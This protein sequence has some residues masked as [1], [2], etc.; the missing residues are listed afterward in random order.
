MVRDTVTQ[1]T[2][3]VDTAER[4]ALRIELADGEDANVFAGLLKK[5]IEDLIEGDDS[6]IRS[7]AKIRGKLGLHSTDPEALVTLVFGEDGIVIRNGFDEDLDGRITGT[8]KLQTETLVGRA[9]PYAAMLRRR[10][11]VGI[12]WSRPLFT[13]QTYSFLKVPK[14]MRP[15]EDA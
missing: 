4:S 1:T 6:K 11:S 14:W 13:L 10:L 7:A 8:L 3:M 15:E 5:H 9:N 12:K 2:T